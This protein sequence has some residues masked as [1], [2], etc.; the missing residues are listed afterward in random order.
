MTVESPRHTIRHAVG[1]D[2]LVVVRVRSADL[3]IRGAEVDD[4]V[5]SAARGET[6]QGLDVV[7]GERS[8]E[9]HA[10]SGRSQDLEI[11][12][13]R[14]ASVVIEGSSSEVRAEGLVGEQRYRLVSGDLTIRASHGS[15]DAAAMS[16]DVDILADGQTR[17]VVRTVSGDVAIRA[18]T[19]AELRVGTTSGDMRLAGRL[20]GEGPFAIETVSGDVVLA[21]AGDLRIDTRTITGDLRSEAPSRIEDVDGQRS[22]VIGSGG[23]TVTFRSTSGDLRVVRA[24]SLHGPVPALS[25]PTIP[26]PVAPPPPSVAA[27]RSIP[28]V[29]PRPADDADLDVLRA[30]ERGDI[31]VAEAGRRLE[32]LGSEE[33]PDA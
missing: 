5:V 17:F 12:V 27:P 23:P 18:G 30:L 6:L 16:G 3:V 11:E 9:I 1:P 32:A 33:T 10:A 28:A 21:S 2:G 31:D 24:L 14:A 19:V 15:I 20:E 26:V 7:R 25:A 4:V 22:L 29:P 8:V 13:P